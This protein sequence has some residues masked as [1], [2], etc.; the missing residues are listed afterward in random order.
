MLSDVVKEY[1]IGFAKGGFIGLLGNGWGREL[2]KKKL[3]YLFIFRE[4][5][6]IF[7]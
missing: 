5:K 1:I 6:K 2:K 4:I 7:K 3:V